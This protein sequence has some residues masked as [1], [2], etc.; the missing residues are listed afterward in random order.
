[1]VERGR[2]NP[3]PCVTPFAPVERDVIL[4]LIDDHLGAESR[5]RQAAVDRLRRFG[6]DDHLAL[7]ALAGVLDPL[8]LDDEHFGGFVV[9]LAGRLDAD[10]RTLLPAFRTKPLG[11]GQLVAA[12]LVPQ[13]ARWSAPAMRP[14]GLAALL[15]LLFRRRR[16]GRRFGDLVIGRPKQERLIRIGRLRRVITPQQGI[17][18]PLQRLAI[19]ALAAQGANQFGDHLLEDGGI[20]GQGRGVDGGCGGAGRL[21]R[22][23]RKGRVRAHAD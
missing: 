21:R 8:M 23:A 1:M 9:V 3:R 5:S 11:F 6:G 18:P 16:R 17:E 20:V 22:R 14:V 12:R 4:I 10:L 13:F 7:A 19:A 2:V 15:W